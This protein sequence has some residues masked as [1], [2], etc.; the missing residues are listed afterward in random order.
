MPC[1]RAADRSGERDPCPWEGAVALQGARAGGG[2]ER[3]V[4]AGD[5][6]GKPQLPGERRHPVENDKI[7]TEVGSPLEVAAL[8]PLPSCVPPFLWCQQLGRCPLCKSPLRARIWL[9][10]AQL[11]MLAPQ[12]CQAASLKDCTS[13][14]EHCKPNGERTRC[15]LCPSPVVAGQQGLEWPKRVC[16]CMRL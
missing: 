1:L 6:L 10:Q 4:R 14:M 5:V 12:K 15:F 11:L 8:E 9:S 16:Q 3:E 7:Q 13:Q 2:G